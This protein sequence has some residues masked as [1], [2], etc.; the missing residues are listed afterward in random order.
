MIEQHWLLSCSTRRMT[1]ASTLATIATLT[2]LSLPIGSAHAQ[3]AGRPLPQDTSHA[4]DNYDILG[5]KLGMPEGEAIAAIKSHLP[6]GSPDGKG[7][8]VRLR[9]LDYQLL[10]PVTRTPVRAGVRFERDSGTPGASDAV[11]ILSVDGRV[12]AVW[13]D[14]VYGRFD[15]D[16][17]LSE[18]SKKYTG[19]GQ[20]PS[21][22]DLI[23]N[24]SSRGSAGKGVTGVELYQGRCTEP[25]LFPGHSGNIKLDAACQKVLWVNYRAMQIAGVRSLSGG[26]A[27]LVDLDAGRR[28]FDAMNGMAA[29]KARDDIK[30]GGSPKL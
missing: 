6:E 15:Y 28:F 27:Q 30:S 1:T 5:V 18:L 24:G 14:D 23:E 12:W 13:R 4:I 26:T 21:L 20:I 2:A 8:T 16:N 17:M 19:A 25:P 11:R 7:H 9:V 22:I 10:S 3:L 29:S